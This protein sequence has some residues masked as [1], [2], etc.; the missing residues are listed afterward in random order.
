MS[1]G[2]NDYAAPRLWRVAER[3]RP[4]GVGREARPGEPR[5]SGARGGAGRPAPPGGEATPA[6]GAAGLPAS[7]FEQLLGGELGGGDA[8]HGL[9]EPSGDARQDL[10]VAEVRGGL[11]DRLR[12]E[13]RVA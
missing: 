3:A 7:G 8:D 5:A 9:A 6:R 12:A 4:E 13:R 1:T 10:G 2:R 11:D